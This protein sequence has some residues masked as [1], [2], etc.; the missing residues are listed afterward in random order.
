[1]ALFL[2]GDVW[3]Y[4]FYFAGRRIRESTKSP[5]KTLAKT[6]EQNRKRELEQGFNNIT[7]TRQ[8]LAVKLSD[9]FIN[10]PL[11]LVLLFELPEEK[12]T[13]RKVGHDRVKES[14][15]AVGAPNKLSLDGRK[16]KILVDLPND[17]ADP[18]RCVFH[19]S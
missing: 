6:A 18:Y 7:D 12:G 3:W 5:S 4:E 9:E 2:R 17:V 14:L 8:E 15:D 16:V 1:M 10:G 13:D 19:R 11:I